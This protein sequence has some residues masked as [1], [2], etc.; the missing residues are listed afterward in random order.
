[1]RR[2][3]RCHTDSDTRAAIDQQV[4]ESSRKYDGFL[5]LTV[6]VGPEIDG[7]LIDIS[8][9]LH[10]EWRHPA[11]GV[12]HRGRRII[13]RGAKVSLPVHKWVPQTPW[14]C[15]AH[16]SV[17][18]R[19]ITMRVVVTHNVTN[20]ASTFAV[21]PIRSVTPVVHREDDASMHRLQAI[22]DIR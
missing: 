12:A 14:L 5:S 6:V 9:D 19:A 22:S 17:I 16:Q 2:D 15:Q 4:G 11:L 1:M 13:S 8:D 10:R 20:H 3:I 18:D 7:L 21:T